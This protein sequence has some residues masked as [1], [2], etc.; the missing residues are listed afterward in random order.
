MKTNVKKLGIVLFTLGSVFVGCTKDEIK[1][2]Q[3]EPT[4]E[5]VKPME[6]DSKKGYSV[7][8]LYIQPA[9]DAPQEEMTD[10]FKG[11]K[12][13]FLPDGTITADNG[14][15]KTGGVWKKIIGDYNEQIIVIDFGQHKKFAPLNNKW[16]VSEQKPAYYAF[17]DKDVS[18]G[19]TGSLVFEL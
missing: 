18:D 11:W 3:A 2:L 5:A 10:K 9:P 16:L 19:V 13:Y 8:S 15:E 4:T 12:L 14:V 17:I 6:M 1:P 7:S